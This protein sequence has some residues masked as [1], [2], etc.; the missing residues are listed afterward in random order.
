MKP[1]TNYRLG[2]TGKSSGYFYEINEFT[3][4]P[5]DTDIETNESGGFLFIEDIRNLINDYLKCQ[6]FIYVHNDELGI[7]EELAINR[8]ITEETKVN[9]N[10]S[11][12]DYYTTIIINGIPKYRDR[13]GFYD[14]KIYNADVEIR[15]NQFVDH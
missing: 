11:I 14:C 9:V 1:P 3:I 12:Q 13:N 2:F 7:V 10:I 5:Y 8:L 4:T 6:L 15:T